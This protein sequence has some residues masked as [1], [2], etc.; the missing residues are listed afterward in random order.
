M[1]PENIR[2]PSGVLMFS[3]VRNATLGINGLRHTLKSAVEVRSILKIV[4]IF[5]NNATCS[6]LTIKVRE[7]YQ[8]YYYS[9]V[10]LLNEAEFPA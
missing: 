4:M 1:P 6:K 7:H 5:K 10:S 3:G 2:K 8:N 9:G